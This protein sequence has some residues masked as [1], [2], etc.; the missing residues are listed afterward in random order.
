MKR[1][2]TLLF[3]LLLASLTYAQDPT[4]VPTIPPLAPVPPLAVDFYQVTAVLV[5]GAPIRP[6]LGARAAATYEFWRKSY[7]FARVDGWALPDGGQPDLADTSTYSTLEGYL[8][9]KIRVWKPISLGALTGISIPIVS[10]QDVEMRYP[11]VWGGGIFVGDGTGK[12]WGFVGVGKHEA[13]GP[14]WKALFSCQV[15]LKG[16][17]SAVVD[18]A[19]GSGHGSFVRVGLAVRVTK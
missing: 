9:A 12:R 15:E 7:I 4:P 8:G 17:V 11:T 16:A 10:G 5:S 13:A 1:T 6:F 14:G 19:V 3:M 2:T 18:G